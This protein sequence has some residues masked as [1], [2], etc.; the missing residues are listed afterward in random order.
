[1]ISGGLDS[2]S[3]GSWAEHWLRTEGNGR[4]AP[5]YVSYVVPDARGDERG[6]LHGFEEKYSRTVHYVETRDFRILEG[7]ESEADVTEN[8]FLDAGWKVNRRVADEMR[9]EGCEVVLSGLGG[10]NIFPSPGPGVFI[11]IGRRHGLRSGWRTYRETCAYYGVPGR[12]FLGPLL[13]LLPP[14]G[15]KRRAKRWLGREIPEWIEPGFAQ[16]SG[17]LAR[18]RQPLPHR[19]FALR[20]QEEDYRELT[21]GRVA[22]MMSYFERLGAAAGFEFRHPFFDPALVRF[23]LLTPLEHKIRNGETKLLLRQAMENILP[24]AVRQRRFKGSLGPFLTRWAREHEATLWRSL[25]KG[26]AAS[27]PYVKPGHV[28]KWVDRFLEGDDEALRPAWNLLS[29]ELWLR[30]S[31]GA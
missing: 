20:T 21:S 22:L 12:S 3:I 17:L 14:P 11:D 25:A 5:L 9:E 27:A 1:M 24:E 15:I 2:T 4:S 6:F 16:R 23:T 26:A 30:N 28:G 31:F 7:I 10:D 13:R 19:G 29:L 18:V 8:A